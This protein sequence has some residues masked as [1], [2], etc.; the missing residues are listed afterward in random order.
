MNEDLIK[1]FEAQV[2]YANKILKELYDW[3]QRLEI[4]TKEKCIRYHDLS[5]FECECYTDIQG[6]IYL[7]TKIQQREK[8]LKEKREAE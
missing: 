2:N 6:M 7:S 8:W 3:E 5:F 4:D 1:I